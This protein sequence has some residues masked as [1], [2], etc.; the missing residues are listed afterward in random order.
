MRRR[1]EIE[2]AAL[3]GKIRYEDIEQASIPEVAGIHSHRC[4]LQP[5][6]AESSIRLHGGLGESAVAQ[7]APQQV[8]RGIVTYVDVRPSIVVVIERDRSQAVRGAVRQPN[9][10]FDGHIGEGSVSIIAVEGV[11][12]GLKS[13]R[14]AE[15]PEALVLAL[16]AAGDGLSGVEL[17]VSRDIEIGAAVAI[18]IEEHGPGGPEAARE[19]AG[20]FRSVAERA[21]TV[22]AEQEIAAVAGDQNI[23]VA[24][25]VIIG[26]GDAHAPAGRPQS[27]LFSDVGEGSVAVVVVQRADRL[28]AASVRFQTG[29]AN[30]HDVEPAVAVVIEERASASDRFED[31]VLA[32]RPLS[33]EEAGE[34]GGSRNIGEARPRGRRES[35]EKPG[36]GRQCK[37]AAFQKSMRAPHSTDRGLPWPVIRPKFALL[38]SVTGPLRFRRLKALKKSARNSIERRSM[39]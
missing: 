33:V 16:R 26:D 38:R 23:I 34:P 6:G 5:V 14:P 24:I 22:V 2:F 28:T 30:Q 19:N 11:R 13:L 7:V 29:A 31:I 36:G 18:V 37:S 15:D 27:S 20:F 21:V 10:G 8:R 39:K 12:I 35:G 9:P 3:T 1:I 17:H 32:R 25:A 4:L